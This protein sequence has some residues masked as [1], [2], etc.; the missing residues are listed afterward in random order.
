MRICRG[1]LLFITGFY[2]GNSSFVIP[3]PPAAAAEAAAHHVPYDPGSPCHP[4]PP[5]RLSLALFNASGRCGVLRGSSRRV[6]A[7]KAPLSRCSM[8]YCPGLLILFLAPSH[9]PR[10]APRPPRQPGAAGRW[11]TL[12]ALEAPEPRRP[13][14]P[15]D[16]RGRGPPRRAA[17][18][19]A[20]QCSACFA[21]AVIK[22]RESAAK[23]KRRRSVSRKLR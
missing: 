15:P 11:W 12:E 23:A 14:V 3:L 10:T 7:S 9:C 21:A 22:A 2:L 18:Q 13:R 1:I 5:Q 8:E 4:M 6:A 16:R 20:V 17:L 19:G